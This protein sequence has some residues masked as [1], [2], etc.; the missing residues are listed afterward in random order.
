MASSDKCTRLL[1]DSINYGCKK[2]YITGPRMSPTVN[3][4]NLYAQNFG[5]IL[6]KKNFNVLNNKKSAVC[7]S[8]HFLCS[9]FSKW[10]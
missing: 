6:K 1:R 4:V 3:A 8:Y 7:C 10:L 9:T 2:F 5:F